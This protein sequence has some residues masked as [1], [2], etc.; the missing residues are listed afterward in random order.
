MNPVIEAIAVA[1][2]GSRV[3]KGVR[4][5]MTDNPPG[6]TLEYEQGDDEL[7]NLANNT[8]RDQFMAIWKK[9]AAW[10]SINWIDPN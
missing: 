6:F 10:K 1:L 7:F 9:A 4:P 3:L 2:N 8:T 5:R